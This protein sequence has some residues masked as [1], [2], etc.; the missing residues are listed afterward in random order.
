MIESFRRSVLSIAL[1]YYKCRR[2]NLMKYLVSA[3]LLATVTVAALGQDRNP[4][5]TFQE[6]IRTTYDF[7]PASLNHAQRSAKSEA[8]DRIWNSV[9]ASR[10]ELLPCLRSALE[11]ANANTFFLFDG[12]NLLV[13][14]DPSPASK[15]LQVRSYVRTNL[16]DVDR[17]VWV[18]IL[19]LRGVEGFD[20]S[21]PAAIWLAYPNTK[22][23]LPEHGGYEVTRFESALFIYGS[24][25]EAVATPALAKVVAQSGNPGREDALRVLMS[26]ATLGSLRELK[27]VDP[28][29][30]SEETQRRLRTLLNSPELLKPRSKPKSSRADFL[31]AFEGIVAE[32]WSM[33]R[34]LVKAVPDGEKDAVAVLKTEDLPLIRKVRRRMI[35][36]GNQHAVEFYN[37]FTD[38]IMALLWRS[39]SLPGATTGA[40]L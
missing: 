16:D 13:D 29:S 4:C 7:H 32:D 5:A 35:A 22:Y 9:K 11:D 17:R 26:Q 20:T 6:Q 8:M 31:K 3:C 37:T 28:S 34:S 30:F 39:R 38:I 10:T 23:F 25:D 19:A 18:T 27:Q 12:S 14:A 40:G 36:N 21:E 2:A 15:G 24:M 1:D 33:F